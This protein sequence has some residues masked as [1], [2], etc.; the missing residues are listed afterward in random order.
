[1]NNRPPIPQT[2][3]PECKKTPANTIFGVKAVRVWT[4]L[5][6]FFIGL[7]I[8]SIAIMLVGSASRGQLLVSAVIQDLFAFALPALVCGWLFVRR[9]WQWNGLTM[10]PGAIALTGVAC[11]F[12]VSIPLLNYTVELNKAL[13]LPDFLSSLE[14]AMRQL[15]DQAAAT[16]GI[17]LGDTSVWGLVS[18]IIII[19]MV[20][21]F[22]EEL[23]FR[24]ALQ[25]TL[26]GKHPWKAVWWT[27]AIF[28]FVHFQMYGFLPRFMLGLWFGYLY[29]WTGS[30]WPS[31][32]AHV[33]N[34]T[35]TVLT[36]WL[37][38]RGTADPDVLNIGA[39]GNPWT[40][41]I[42]TILTS[43]AIYAMCSLYARKEKAIYG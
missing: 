2:D 8:A 42:S 15:E 22:C 19:G 6:L 26:C 43:A 24:G 27:A 37:V 40:V 21:P 18:G 31:V 23:F 20:G 7:F 10:K 41:I 33:L 25:K 12:I 14:A 17:L 39:D 38:M 16:T 4:L 32:L 3:M 36:Q 13:V 9:P 28:S 35:A 5:A 29:L 34:N 30:L 1:M 11:V